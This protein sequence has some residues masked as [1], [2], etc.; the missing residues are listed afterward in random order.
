MFVPIYRS[1]YRIVSVYFVCYIAS[2]QSSTRN[3]GVIVS[4]VEDEWILLTRW[5]NEVSCTLSRFP[6]IALLWLASFSRFIGD[7]GTTTDRPS[8]SSV[9]SHEQFPLSVIS[10]IISAT[11]VSPMFAYSTIPFVRVS[12]IWDPKTSIQTNSPI[13]KRQRKCFG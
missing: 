5:F 11:L 7:P 9:L 10:L 2:S 4:V 13:I 1:V 3:V 12:I 8:Y 6:R